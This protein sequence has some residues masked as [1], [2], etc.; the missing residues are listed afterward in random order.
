[1]NLYT[2]LDDH[3]CIVVGRRRLQLLRRRRPRGGGAS[4]LKRRRLSVW[5]KRSASHWF[6]ERLAQ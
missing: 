6:S 5:L 1:M 2:V 4:A 3:L